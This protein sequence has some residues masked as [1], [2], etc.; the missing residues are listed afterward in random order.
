MTYSQTRLSLSTECLLGIS[1]ETSLR[2]PPPQQNTCF[3]SSV[4]WGKGR[5]LHEG[6][7]AFE[8]SC[9]LLRQQCDMKTQVRKENPARLVTI[10]AGQLLRRPTTAVVLRTAAQEARTYVRICYFVSSNPIARSVTP[11][12]PILSQIDPK[13]QQYLLNVTATIYQTPAQWGNIPS[14]R[15]HVTNLI[16]P[17]PPFERHN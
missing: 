14:Y 16:P 15:L 17:F 4:V 8:H 12:P 1:C 11:N 6:E 9:R 7:A 13:P 10:S 5:A 3:V 2:A